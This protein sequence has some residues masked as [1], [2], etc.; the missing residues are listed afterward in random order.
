MLVL[1]ASAASAILAPHR[2]QAQAPLGPAQVSPGQAQMSPAPARSTQPPIE[3][4]VIITRAKN[5][6]KPGSGADAVFARS[7][8]WGTAIANDGPCTLYS[9]VVTGGLS[10]GTITITGTVQ[11]ITLEETATNE[12]V[13]YKHS[14]PVPP[15]SFVD[16]ST[17]KVAAAG[18]T[19]V[20]AFTATVNAPPELT[21]YVPPTSLV[22]RGYTA[23][24]TANPGTEV[25]IVIGAVN[26][27]MRGG[28]LVMC[29]A[30][31]T[32]SF[33]VPA[34]TFAMIPPAFSTAILMV[35]RVAKTVQTVGDAQITVEAM[36]SVG[37]GPF[38]LRAAERSE[39]AVTHASTLPA[40][41]RGPCGCETT[42]RRYLSFAFGLGGVSRNGDAPPTDSGSWRL[43]LGQRIGHGLHLV[44]EANSLGSGYISLS[45]TDVS[46]E[47]LSLGA[48]ARWTPFKPRPQPS[49]FIGPYVDARAF[50][51]TAVVGANIRDRLTQTSTKTTDETAWSPMVS[52]ALGLQEI[53]GHDWSL[54]P[55][56]R[57]QLAYYD[58][59]LQRGWML[60]IAIHLNEW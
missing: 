23:T 26:R 29:R 7:P 30:P 14:A 17:I 31:D 3:G 50:Y 22:R 33:T 28:V 1:S 20:P 44:E 6:G 19:D 41:S 60:L 34:S 58:G 48:G 4:H 53:Q 42:P 57:E 43:Q 8:L 56:F 45:P 54:G 37:S 47:Q 9:H 5:P 49:G 18:G 2:V 38:I 51:V 36:D 55:E 21:G 11:P 16:G 12:G 13:K 32:G 15:P 24:W 52:L 39:D 27:R 10:A 46:E 35:A 25:M 40:R 59:H